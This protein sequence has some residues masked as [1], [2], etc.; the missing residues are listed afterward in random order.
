MI[1]PGTDMTGKG[2]VKCCVLDVVV[3]T[4]DARDPRMRAR[5]GLAQVEVH[6]K[7][8]ESDG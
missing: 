1:L 7:T 4:R 2:L 3:K 6:W 5:G 8:Q